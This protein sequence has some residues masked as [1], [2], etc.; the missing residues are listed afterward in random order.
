MRFLRE[1]G[2][3]LLG[4]LPVAY[5]FTADLES[6]RATPLMKLFWIFGFVCMVIYVLRRMKATRNA[7]RGRPASEK[8]ERADK[9]QP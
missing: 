2:L 6:T 1:H 5:L 3:L 8:E 7:L 9:D 4:L